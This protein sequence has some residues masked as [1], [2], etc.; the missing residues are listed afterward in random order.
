M[1]E[2]MAHPGLPRSAAAP[3]GGS[4]ASR[5]RL[6]VDIEPASVIRQAACAMVI[7]DAQ[8][9]I[10]AANPACTALTGLAEFELLGTPLTVGRVGVRSGSWEATLRHADGGLRTVW[11]SQA[12][13]RDRRGD[14]SWLVVTI[15]DISGLEQERQSLRHQAEHDPLTGLPNRALFN[16]EFGRAMARAQRHQRRLALAFIDLDGFKPINDRFGHQAGDAVLTELARR[17]RAAVRAEDLVARWGGDEFVVVLDDP[18]DR[19]A[20]VRAA[21]V[22][23]AVIGREID[24]AGQ[25]LRVSASIGVAAVPEDGQSCDGL[26]RAADAA[27]YRGK[28]AGGGQ[29]IAADV[30]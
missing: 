25:R 30:A 12:P 7:T 27:M 13:L 24:C 14:G 16:I 21:R 9:S 29:V 15:S 22:L 26:L 19:A 17:L 5:P 2:L 10:V 18:P 11:V 1:L 20:A 23:R 6:V 28:Q 4:V 3:G 8:L